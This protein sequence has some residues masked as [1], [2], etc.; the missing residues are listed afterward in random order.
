MVRKR[1]GGALTRSQA[2][3]ATA[4][5]TPTP[6]PTPTPAPVRR[7][8]ATKRKKK[9]PSA[10]AAKLIKRGYSLRDASR[11]IASASFHASA[12]AREKNP[13]L[14]NVKG[15]KNPHRYFFN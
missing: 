7:T 1:K 14:G 15:I 6:T 10:A 8:R 2:R 9:A 12:K 11:I 5:P 3:R 13:K 4:A